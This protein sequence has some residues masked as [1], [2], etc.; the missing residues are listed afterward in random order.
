MYRNLPKEGGLEVEQKG[1]E[2]MT[3]HGTPKEHKEAWTWENVM[4]VLLERTGECRSTRTL[5]FMLQSLGFLPSTLGSY[6]SLKPRV[7]CSD[8]GP[9]RALPAARGRT[10]L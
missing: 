3:T 7:T 5:Q 4:S 6:W 8:L 9:R 1:H 2:A 10:C